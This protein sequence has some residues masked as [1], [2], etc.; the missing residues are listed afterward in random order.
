[1]TES[2]EYWFNLKTKEVEVGKQSAALF[3][4]GPF[5]TYEEAEKAETLLAERA[6]RWREEEADEND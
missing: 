1:M 2:T 6:A 5:A 4:V 3:R